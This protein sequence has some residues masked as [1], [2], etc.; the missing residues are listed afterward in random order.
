MEFGSFI[1]G[2]AEPRDNDRHAMNGD[3][4]SFDGVRQRVHAIL[5]SVDLAPLRETDVY[6]VR[7]L[8]GRVRVLVDE[9]ASDS[10]RGVLVELATRLSRELGAHGHPP[11]ASLLALDVS[12]STLLGSSA[13]KIADRIFWVDRLVTG[14]G[15]RTVNTSASRRDRYTL[16]SVEGGV[17][18]STTA[19]VLA[20]HLAQ[21][22][23]RVLV[24]DLDVESPGL[25]SVVLDQSAQPEFG[26][27][28][29]FVEDLVGQ[30]A[31]VLERMIGTPTWA[32]DLDGSVAVVPAHG[33]HPGEYLAK[34]GRIHMATDLPWTE[35]PDRVIT[36]LEDAWQPTMLVID[37][38]SGLHDTAAA[39]VTSI[40][41]HVLLFATDSES[42]WT[43]CERIF[44]H[45]R[46]HD[47][48]EKMRDRLSIVS[49]L[50][51]EID[52][53][54]YLAAF[55]E[56]CR[57]LFRCHLFDGVAPHEFSVPHSPLPIHWNRR[58]AAG[59]SLRR[60]DAASVTLAYSAFLRS[61]DCRL[62]R[63]TAR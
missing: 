4:Q 42:A 23:E 43:T 7:D 8:Y 18:R 2:V 44:S 36:S 19:V 29:W 34:L 15:W 6:F 40:G 56:R 54:K 48:A 37:G 31:H 32:E 20:W 33:R 10:V 59:S 63:A 26:I 12:A 62:R 11:D 16:Y 35:R 13:R 49:A 58:L 38:G 1:G 50:T 9:P 53:A 41:A 28:D 5:G 14:N 46:T 22:G 55:T 17:G 27:V 52:T 39:A 25:G 3:F 24:V 21:Q 47:L 57:H 45:W 61:F 30:G 60:I 51:P